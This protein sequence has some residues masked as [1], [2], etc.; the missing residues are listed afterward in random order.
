MYFLIRTLVKFRKRNR[1]VNKND[2]NGKSFIWN[3]K[4]TNYKTIPSLEVNWRCAMQM[5]RHKLWFDDAARSTSWASSKR[6]TSCRG[7][8][9]D[10]MF[11]SVAAAILE[12]VGKPN[13]KLQMVWTKISA[14]QDT[15]ESHWKLPGWQKF[16]LFP[17]R[18]SLANHGREPDA[19][20]AQVFG[21][22][23]WVT[24]RCDFC[25]ELST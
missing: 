7:S 10:Q 8:S 12:K 13:I 18:L 9:A 4:Q 5:W 23:W 15:E 25:W 19:K 16:D 3:K 22:N 21:H 14:H 11:V 6:R 20:H 24:I 2:L 17:G 1:T